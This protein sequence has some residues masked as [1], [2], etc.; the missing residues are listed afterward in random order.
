MMHDVCRGACRGACWTAPPPPP[1][2]RRQSSA[3]VGFTSQP[4]RRLGGVSRPQPG[5]QRQAQRRTACCSPRWHPRTTPPCTHTGRPPE[6][7]HSCGTSRGPA[8]RSTTSCRR[9]HP[10]AAAGAR[11][12]RSA[13]SLVRITPAWGKGLMVTGYLHGSTER[14]GQRYSKQPEFVV[15]LPPPAPAQLPP[16]PPT[17]EQGHPTCAS[18]CQQGWRKAGFA[19][20][21]CARRQSIITP[22]R[23]ASR[24]GGRRTARS[25]TATWTTS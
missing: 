2:R 10:R 3:R 5:Q 13:P 24:G 6:G 25:T 19:C 8:S 17:P 12:S 4:R 16:P 7:W 9:A 20:G 15:A 11:A 14:D 23:R 18:V 22:R 1:P 21:T